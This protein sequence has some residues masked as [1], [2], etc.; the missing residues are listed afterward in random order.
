MHH[1]QIGR[2][3][4]RKWI[5][6]TRESLGA[7]GLATLAITAEGVKGTAAKF[8]TADEV[9]AI[10]SKTGAGVGD[11]ILFAADTHA[12]VNKVLSGLRV[13]LRDK[14]NLADKDLMAF[15]WIVDFPMFA[16]NEEE[17][18]WDAEHHPFTM[19]QLDDLPKFETNPGEILSDAYDMVCNGYE[20]ASGSIRIHRSDIH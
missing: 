6:Q 10:K 14:L 5:A 13:A 2:D 3:D 17:K 16:W 15:A 1:P 20:M 7:K 18:K 9:E 8:V 19:P 12:V 11:L 4:A